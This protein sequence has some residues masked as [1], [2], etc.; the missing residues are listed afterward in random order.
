MISLASPSAARRQLV[1]FVTNTRPY[2]LHPC[3][4]KALKHCKM[5]CEDSKGGVKSQTFYFEKFFGSLSGNHYICKLIP[6][7]K[8]LIHLLWN[9][10]DRQ[11][12]RKGMMSSENT[13]HGMFRMN[14]SSPKASSSSNSGK[15][16]SNTY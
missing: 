3:Q 2:I 14:E 8:T 12:N 13:S 7:V 4:F 10:I 9:R 1:P 15:N 6:Q 11:W 5:Q 16:P